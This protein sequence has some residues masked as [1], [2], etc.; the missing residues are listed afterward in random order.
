MTRPNSAP[1]TRRKAGLR[2]LDVPVGMR[3]WDP[4]VAAMLKL[5]RAE[6]EKLTAEGGTK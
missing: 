4:K 2:R 1:E 3:Q 5:L 6:I